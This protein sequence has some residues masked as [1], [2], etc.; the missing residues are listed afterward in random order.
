MQIEY[1]PAIAACE[2]VRRPYDARCASARLRN[3]WQS[4]RGAASPARSCCSCRWRPL[5][6]AVH[7]GRGALMGRLH[8]HADGSLHEHDDHVDDHRH[9]D[10]SPPSHRD[11]GDHSGY[12]DSG[13]S[14][15]AV[16][17]R[18]LDEND[19]V[20]AANRELLR[21]HGVR[22]VNLMSAP[23]AGK[24]TLLKRTLSTLS[25]R[26]RVGVLEGD[27]ATSLDADQLD[28]LGAIVSLVNTSAGFGGECHLDAVMVRSGLGRLPLADLDL[29]V[30]ENVGNLVCPAEFDVGEDAKAMVYAVTEGDD[31]PLKYPVMFRAVDVV[32]INKIDLLPHLDVDLDRF[33][34]NLQAVNPHA[35]TILASARTGQGVD[36]WCQLAD[37]DRELRPSGVNSSARSEREVRIGWCAERSRD[38]LPGFAAASW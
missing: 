10:A 2:D 14:R 33:L 34:D 25:E 1:V 18:I 31:K 16:L 12:A 36:E 19:R 11:V 28:G 8:R 23:G 17:E 38:R 13:T 4:C 27:I 30:I 3:L 26:V 22:T 37:V 29:L 9:D 32:V 5:V 24:T 21:A 35:K 20:A 15:I 6:N 7:D